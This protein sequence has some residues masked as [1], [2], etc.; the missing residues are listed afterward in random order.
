MKKQPHITEQT[1]KKLLDVFWKLYT[2]DNFAKIT[3]KKVCDIAKYDRTT[4]YRYFF[5]INDI[6]NQLEDE[7]I[8]NIKENISI[9][10]KSKEPITISVDG[11]THFT[12]IY[13]EYIVIFS[14]KGNM[15]FYKK[16][17]ELI[18]NDVYKYLSINVNDE[19]K[20]DFI[21]E[22]IFSSLINS[23]VYWYNHQNTMTIESFI[24]FANNILSTGTNFIFK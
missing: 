13:G 17:K 20:K 15:S 11:F 16:F 5:D 1:R 6:L 9:K 18:K 3:V 19:I 24:Q 22:F 12:K 23:F 14:E 2:K 7:L 8:K 21:F 10:S 4:F